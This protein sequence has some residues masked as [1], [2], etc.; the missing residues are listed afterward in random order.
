MKSNDLLRVPVFV[1]LSVVVGLLA[2]DLKAQDRLPEHSRS[3]LP[4]EQVKTLDKLA[5]KPPSVTVA[6]G[7][8]A[9]DTIA[10]SVALPA[11][12]RRTKPSRLTGAEVLEPLFRRLHDVA[13]THASEDSVRIVHIGDSHVRGHLFPQTAGERL[14]QAF[15][16]V[17]YTDM[18]VNG[19]TCL[20]FTHAARIEEIAALR[21]ELV[22]LSFGTNESHNRRYGSGA[23]YR[24]MDELI[25]L[26]QEALPDVPLLL[27]TPPGAYRRVRLSRRRYTHTVNPNTPVAAETIRRYASRHKLALWDLY[28]TAG[29]R[30]RA[31]RN[32]DEAGLYRPDHVH[33]TPEGYELQGNLLYQAFIR[34]YNDFV[35]TH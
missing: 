18:G 8:Q 33:F 32:W 2:H 28:E 17:K 23:H 3:T 30:E 31:C 22:I 5:V 29:G 25:K 20:T 14:K 13:C 34:A 15:G 7:M 19:A 21:P 11:A 4:S 10:C 1:G 35:I 26:L 6:T 12:F 16:A 27:T 24:Q 9:S